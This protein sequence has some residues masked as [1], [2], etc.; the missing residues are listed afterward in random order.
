MR[1]A[2]RI[3]AVVT[4]A[5]HEGNRLYLQDAS[6]AI[7]ISDIP[8]RQRFDAGDLVRVD[9]IRS[10]RDASNRNYGLSDISVR[11]V[12]EGQWPRAIPLKAQEMWNP[13][14]RARVV[15]LRGIV[16]NFNSLDELV[17]TLSAD[18]TNVAVMVGQFR[19]SDLEGLLDAEVIAQGVCAQYINNDGKVT[20]VRL[21]AANFRLLTVERK[22]LLDPFGIEAT[23]LKQIWAGNTPPDPVQRVRIQGLVESQLVGE[24]L[25]ISEGD[26]KLAIYTTQYTPLAKGDRIE[27]IGFV[28]ERNGQYFLEQAQ[29][30][31]TESSQ[32]ELITSA[33]ADVS[34]PT[35]KSL[36][37]VLKLTREQAR[38]H[39]PVKVR[40]TV[41][42]YD[43]HWK[44]LFIQDDNAGIY[45]SIG[46][47]SF[48]V[49]AG[50]V[51]EVVG[52]T[53]PGGI[54]SMIAP[55][56]I[57]PLGKTR[58]P[59]PITISYQQ[60]I[61][62]TYD[63]RRVKL[64][65]TV[66]N[67]EESGGH[68]Q[69]ELAGA[70]GRFQCTI[71]GNW[72]SPFA[73]N[74]INTVV[75]VSGICIVN[76]NS[77]RMPAS[78]TLAIN[79]ERD[80]EILRPSPADEFA[81]EAQPIRDVLQFVSPDKAQQRIKI[82]GTVTL[83]R[84]GRELYIQDTSGAIRA[85]TS[86]TNN[87]AVGDDV[88]A[89]GFR[90]VEEFVPMLRNV[91]FRIKRQGLPPIARRLEP[92]MALNANNHGRLALIEGRLVHSVPKSIA[93]ELLLEDGPLVFTATVEPNEA[94]RLCPAY[95][96]GSRMQITGIC[97][98]RAD[99]TRQPRAFR[100]L[101]RSANDINVLEKPSWLTLGR[102]LAITFALL[103]AVTATSAWVVALQGRVRHQTTLIRQRLEREASL[104]ERCRELIEHA[105]DAIF[106]YD[107]QGRLL[108]INEAGEHMLGYARGE[109]LQLTLA[110][111]VAPEHHARLREFMRDDPGQLMTQMYELKMRTRDGR[112][113][114]LELSTR[115]LKSAGHVVGFE[116]IAR[117]VTSRKLA[118]EQLRHSEARLAEAQRIGHVG[119]WE[120]S[121]SSRQLALSAE[122]RRLLE[123]GESLCFVPTVMRRMPDKDRRQVWAALKLAIRGARTLS[124]DHAL[125][126]PSK[127]ER[128]VHTRIEAAF[129][130]LGEC[131]R[132]Y[133]TIEDVTDRRAMELQL[134][135]AQKMESVGQL[136]AGVAHDF[137][138]LLTVI[139]G[140]T[141]LLLEDNRLPTDCRDSLGQ[142]A[143]SSERAADLTRQLLAFSRK[144]FIQP[145]TL[146]LNEV[147]ASTVKMLG[148]VLGEHINLRLQYSSPLPAVKADPSMIS[149]VI[150]NL[151][152][153]SRDAM[154][155]GG[156]LEIAT[157]EAHLEAAT[158]RKM[159]DARPGHFVCLRI[160][161]TGNG[162]SAD[163][164]SHLFEPFFTTKDIGKG[165]GLGLSTVYGIVK[166]HDGFIEVASQQGK[167]T[168]FEVYLPSQ[169]KTQAASPVEPVAGL[170]PCPH[171]TVLVVE[172]EASLR[173]LAVRVITQ[174]GCQAMAAANGKEALDIWAKHKNDISMLLTDMVMPDGISG[175][176]LAKQLRAQKPELKVVYTSGYSPELLNPG[177]EIQEG[178]NFLS[179]PYRPA[180]LLRTLQNCLQSQTA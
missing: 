146:D 19:A 180:T 103:G 10:V 34:L 123:F 43:K 86:Q 177:V 118:E 15:E 5:S 110:E 156:H 84:P 76:V 141:S 115:T 87:V 57:T 108:S 119:S 175:G 107:L 96:A 105:N 83:S 68:L 157:R 143:A 127:A 114:V 132:L 179:K 48:P 88:E 40:A 49:E 77:A 23:P 97:F 124:L 159:S 29:Y 35:L 58:L 7:A 36:Q 169:I 170:N 59:T 41:T 122:A 55:A 167:G 46:D 98:V 70:D 27:A 100:I 135:Q 136:A 3:Q 155:N 142:I 22:G 65:G 21:A 144:Q 104:E 161:D 85:Q 176:E 31:L 78:I 90:T 154:P 54:L 140:N 44:Q 12:G 128:V 24:S 80:L 28:S 32:A 121:M 102:A 133:G 163:T 37:Q 9:A 56:K 75:A 11:Q 89:V 62:G 166:Q 69:F 171:M 99:E 13:V 160:E 168:V 72:N 109:A 8:D 2:V 1:Q 16:R 25:V 50:E 53:M 63:S 66:Q 4:F 145:R 92:S 113:L 39:Y 116:S 137:N 131:T 6:G 18:G 165:T 147:V 178:V 95:E 101:A 93:P 106:T 120:F 73:S 134:R 67:L 126:V 152:V 138:N 125:R 33:Q 60:A 30:R 20:G 151:A 111:I 38:K 173:D 148:R 61:A 174:Q 47:S 74:L 52:M 172:D 79:N 82:E 117:N 149:Q 130:A 71:P 150:M 112:Q 51:V 91:D 164:V 81:G 14:H 94:G 26:Q 139:Q 45:L 64:V 42:H 153:N 162:M 158:A 129:N 17:M